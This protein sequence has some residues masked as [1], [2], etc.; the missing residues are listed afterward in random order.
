MQ[1]HAVCCRTLK[2]SQL[3]VLREATATATASMV[4][5]SAIEHRQ[6]FLPHTG[7][8]T[9]CKRSSGTPGWRPSAP[10]PPP[11]SRQRPRVLASKPRR[12]QCQHARSSAARA[13]WLQTVCAADHPAVRRTGRAGGDCKEHRPATG[14]ASA[15]SRT[16]TGCG[17]PDPD[18]G[19]CWRSAVTPAPMGAGESSGR[20]MSLG[21]G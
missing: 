12:R 11:R 4:V 21:R 5:P 9:A 3:Q 19:V 16:S 6:W 18:C 7:V 15:T 17:S 1:M 10:L 2:T 8:R 20:A 14:A 13:A